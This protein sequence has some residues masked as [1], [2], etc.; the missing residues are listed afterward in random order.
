SQTRTYNYD[1]LGRL[2]SAATPESGTTSYYYTT[3][4]GGLCSGDPSAVCRRIRPEANQ[5]N[6]GVTTTTTYLYDALN[7]L[8]QRQY[9]GSMSY[10]TYTYDLSSVWGTN[11]TN[12]KGRMVGA[13]VNG[14]AT[15]F[16]TYDALGR[17]KQTEQCTPYNCGAT[18]WTMNYT[19]DL[20]G[21]MLTE[22]YPTGLTVTNTYNTY[23][24]LTQMT[25]TFVDSQ[26]PSLLAQVS[27]N[28]WG[29]L[30]TL[31]NG[32]AGS[33]CVQ[34]RETYD[35]NN[36]LQ[37][38]RIQLGTT[39]SSSAYSC[40]VYNYY[41]SLGNPG[42]CGVPSQGTGDNGNVVGYLYQDSVNASLTHKASYAYDG[43]NRLATASA[44]P[45]GSGTV[46]YSQSYNYTSDGSNGRYGNMSC[47]VGS[48]GYCPQ[49]TY[50]SSTN[51]I[52]QIG[53][54]SAGY[55]AAGDVTSDG[56]HTYQWD[57]KGQLISVDNGST[58]TYQYDALGQRIRKVVG[59]EIL[60]SQYDILGHQVAFGN[61][62]PSFVT[63]Q[64]FL[65]A[66]DRMAAYYHVGTR[67]VHPDALGSTTHSTD[68]AGA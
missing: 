41:T 27:Y 51:R 56:T 17:I 13:Y 45:F 39:S 31:T 37:P 57:A 54:A 11:T 40:R 52:N 50:D 44:T 23:Q 33:G 55:D 42:S 25:S 68:Q 9:T 18:P 19:Y 58:A 26:H 10:D 28:S 46:S 22:T 32:C 34:S 60:D 49:V 67:F 36:R 59:S 1:S 4:G 62:V 3:S 7:R 63:W 64:D 66:G 20:A 30:A 2:T 61:T 53:S 48:S 15:V 24:Q 38:V 35:Y 43:A 16:P 21:D 5:T 12:A 65:Y 29:G 6:P 47:T 8:T 14:A